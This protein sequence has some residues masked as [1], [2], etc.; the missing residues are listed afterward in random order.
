MKTL[1]FQL[2]VPIG[3][4]I[5]VILLVVMGVAYWNTS[6]VLKTNVIR[7][8][9]LS[10]QKAANVFDIRFQREKTIM[11]SF[12]KQGTAQFTALQNDPQMQLAFTKTKHEDYSQWN[13]VSFLPDTSGKNVA[14]NAGKFVDASKLAYVKKIPV[15]GKTF[16][17]NPILSVTTGKSIVVGAAPIKINNQ[18][19]GAVVGGIPLDNF[20]EE[21]H[22]LKIG[23]AGFCIATAPDGMIVSHPKAE[24]V[25]KKNITDLKNNDLTEA[26]KNIQAGKTGNFVTSIDGVKY[27]AAY[28]PTQDKWGVII[29]MP[30]SEAFAPVRTLTWIFVV[31]F[32]LGLAIAIGVITLIANR[33]S[34]PVKEMSQYADAIASGDLSEKTLQQIDNSQYAADDEI[35]TLRKAMIKMR[36]KLAGLMGK[37]DDSAVHTA[38]SSLQLKESA[39]QSAQT[40]T[41]VAEAVTKV[42]SQTV[43]GQEALDNITEVF[44]GFMQDVSVMR[45]NTLEANKSADFAV[46]KT[47]NGTKTVQKAK[48]QMENINISSKNVTAAVNELSNGTAKIGEIVNIISGIAGQ[49]NLLALN[50]AIEAA[51]A[52]EQGKGFAVVA[53]EV[54]KLAE[55][56]QNSAGQIISLINEINRDV[57]TAVTAVEH[58]DKDVTDGLGNVDAAEKQFIEIADLIKNVQ[59][60]SMQVLSHVDE[61]FKKGNTVESSS[62]EVQNIMRETAAESQNVSAATEE[63]SASMEEIAASSEDLAQ[64][65][66]ALKDILNK[67]KLK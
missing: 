39:N 30:E 61:L 19:V 44:D 17:D 21:I 13:P 45:D 38:A 4:A 31:L 15:I 66:D 28:A 50:A 37:I 55:Q 35:G 41:Q 51:R 5:A 59:Q 42:S 7:R 47:E 25:M 8:I 6:N 67:F 27:L 20:T 49:T 52:G 40:A 29:F 46:E 36:E 24:Y 32:I 62:H 23:E 63:Q 64:L 65:S 54:R 1:K 3:S 14:T 57:E 53:D 9:E 16:M 56:S 43:R 2:L 12:G 22:K 11:D 18:V 33:V 34:K 58:S 26:L 60:R 48:M 10:A